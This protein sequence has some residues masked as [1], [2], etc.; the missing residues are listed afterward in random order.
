MA[1]LGSRAGDEVV[2]YGVV[3]YAGSGEEAVY[4]AGGRQLAGGAFHELAGGGEHEDA[5]GHAQGLRHVVGGE[6]D[7]FAV[8]AC[9]SSEHPEDFYARRHVEEREG[10][11]EDYERRFLR[12]GTRYHGFLTLAVAEF[13]YEGVGLV[14][15]SHAPHGAVGD[16][17]VFPGQSP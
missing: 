15:D 3:G 6:E 9:E 7:S 12:Q 5:V 14:C 8:V 4:G 1:F 11:V 2:L 10:F 13:G 16:G 17:A